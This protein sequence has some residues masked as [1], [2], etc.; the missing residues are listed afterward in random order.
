MPNESQVHSSLRQWKP[1]VKQ[2]CPRCYQTSD[3]RFI[4]LA[5]VKTVVRSSVRGMA[6]IAQ[7]K[8]RTDGCGQLVE[9][10]VFV[11]FEHKTKQMFPPN[12]DG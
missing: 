2:Y 3:H 6:Y 1:I 4:K 10:E 9:V 11:P 12:R 8:C 7:Y 5:G